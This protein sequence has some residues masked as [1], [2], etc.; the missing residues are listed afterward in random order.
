MWIKK[1]TF[2]D[3]VC[4]RYNL[5]IKQ[6]PETY[7][8]SKPFEVKHVLNCKRGGFITNSHNSVGDIPANLLR[9]VTNE[10]HIEPT[11]EP[12][13]GEVFGNAKNS[14]KNVRLGTQPEVYGL[15]VNP[16]TSM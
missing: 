13:M 4:T 7:T 15:E 16:L 14:P 5:P 2:W 9:E 6:L 11:S 12:R 8:G 3:S 1:R 10:V